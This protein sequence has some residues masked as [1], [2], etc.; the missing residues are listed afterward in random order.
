MTK[1]L[2]CMLHIYVYRYNGV[3]AFEEYQYNSRYDKW[4]CKHTWHGSLDVPQY[5]GDHVRQAATQVELRK[6]GRGG[7][8]L[9][10]DIIYPAKFLYGK[11][12]LL[13]G[14]KTDEKPQEM[15]RIGCYSPLYVVVK[16]R[17]KYQYFNNL[18]SA[19]EYLPEEVIPKLVPDETSPISE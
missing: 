15:L 6:E 1:G 13:V 8:Q 18:K 16:F 2:H 10:G 3:F 5:L 19:I 7:W 4:P 11:Y 9:T 17:L 14:F 12:V